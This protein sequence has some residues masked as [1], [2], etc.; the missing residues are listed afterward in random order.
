MIFIHLVGMGAT[1][2]EI[3]RIRPLDL[4]RVHHERIEGWIL[5]QAGIVFDTKAA[6]GA[7]RVV[8]AA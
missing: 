3:E 6:P 4:L 1:D 8:Q 5:E 2:K 7:L